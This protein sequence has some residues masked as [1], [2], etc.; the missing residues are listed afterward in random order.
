[1]LSGF[2]SRARDLR[3]LQEE[4]LKSEVSSILAAAERHSNNYYAWQHF[5]R[6]LLLKDDSTSKPLLFQSESEQELLNRISQWCFRNPSDTSGWS[7][8]LYL[9]KAVDFSPTTLSNTV[10]EMISFASRVHWE[11]EALWA[12]VRTALRPQY[13]LN[14]NARKEQHDVV[15]DLVEGRGLKVPHFRAALLHSPISKDEYW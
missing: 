5:R 1:V 11:R 14:E 12:A 9:L 13:L 6:L 4:L 10:S 3:N 2:V 15:A 8:L 7:T